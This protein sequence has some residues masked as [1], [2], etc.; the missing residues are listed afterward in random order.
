MVKLGVIQEG[1]ET[2]FSLFS[3]HAT[4]VELRL[5]KVDEK[6]PFQEVSLTKEGDMW[7]VTL[8][9]LPETFE[10]TYRC[11]GPYNPKE[12]HLFNKEIDLVD[13]YAT[14]LNQSPLWNGQKQALR[15]V[16]TPKEPF[17]WEEDARPMIPQEELIIYE[18]HVRGFTQD[19]S[20]RVKHPGTFLGMIEKIPF[21][22]ELGIN[23][24]ELLP[25]HTFNEKEPPNY[26][27]YSTLNFFTPMR[28]YGTQKELKMLVKA[29]HQEGIEVILDVV[30]NHTDDKASFR[31]IDNA[32]YYIVDE[33]GDHNYSGC[34]NTFNCNHP[35]AAHLIVDSLRHFVTEFHIDGFRFDLAPILTRGQEGNPMENPPV[36]EMIHR[37]PILAPTKLIAEPWDA[38]GLYLGGKFPSYR[39]ACWNDRFRDGVRHFI[40]GDGNAKEMKECIL[41]SPNLYDSPN[42]SIN[43]ITAHDGFS[44]SDLVSYNEKHNEANGEN[45]KD[46]TDHNISWNCGEEGRSV[47]SEI[48][49]LRQKQ[50]MN[51]QLALMVSRGVPMVLMG[52]EYGHTKNGNNNAWC[53]DNELNHFLWN[54]IIRIPFLVDLI[55]LRKEHLKKIESIDWLSDAPLAFLV[56][57]TLLIAFNPSKETVSWPIP[58]GNWKKIIDTHSLKGELTSE[59]TLHPFSS[60]VLI[61][62]S[63]LTH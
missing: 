18:M 37:D 56:N 53:Q 44:L 17:D 21:L 16:V 43:F 11:D 3:K 47:K 49:F 8:P 61:S 40:R 48:L 52:D 9:S 51:F 29:L 30:Y 46:G 39:F 33:N 42:K 31:G 1:N 58:S 35:A 4:G 14:L 26:W 25:I 55:S 13:P 10:Y 5:F 50:M 15:G 60:I 6:D 32:S 36:I 12:G 22:K 54:R 62:T 34:G 19:A 24:V 45:S 2:T 38:A 28:P 57:K 20:S 23:A 7:K 59:Y 41:G 63:G 27:G